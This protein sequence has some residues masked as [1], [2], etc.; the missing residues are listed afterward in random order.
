M[1]DQLTPRDYR[2]PGSVLQEDMATMLRCHPEAFDCLIFAAVAGQNETVAVAEDVVGALDAGERAQTF[3]TPVLGRALLVPEESLDFDVLSG[4]LAN[5]FLGASTP[6]NILLSIPVR[7]YSLIQ[8]KEYATPDA[9][10]P[11]LRTVYVLSAKSAGHTAGAGVVYVCAPLPALGEVPDL[12]PPA[13]EPE[14]DGEGQPDD[15]PHDHTLAADDP[16]G[17]L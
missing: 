15:G 17:V 10:E 1:I 13:E 14:P 11:E 5:S 8:W 4:E 6:L 3:A 2:A 16:V 9:E 7:N 12:P